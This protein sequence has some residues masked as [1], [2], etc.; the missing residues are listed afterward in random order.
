MRFT[1]A[2]PPALLSTL[3]LLSALA[4]L[5]SPALACG[6]DTDCTV[7]GDRTYR[8]YVP[9]TDGPVGAFFYAHGYRGSADGAMGNQALRAMADR[10]GMAFIAMNAD[11]DD[12]NLAHRPQAPDQTEAAEYDY[13]TAVIEDVASRIDLDQTR[14]FSTGFSAGGMMTW[15]LACAMGDRFAGF[16]P[17]S[18]TF[19]QSAPATCPTPAAD[20]V[21]IHGERDTVVPMEGRA[22]AGTRQGNVYDVMSMYAD[23]GQQGAAVLQEMPEGLTCFT[24]ENAA[25]TI[26]DLCM[27]DGGHS[28]SA[29]RVEWAIER[30]LSRL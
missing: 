23:F 2:T 20:L 29:A 21:H 5:A 12:W 17:Y 27:F 18:G 22:I 13:V 6:P 11:A 10:L 26:L 7:S 28:F 8:L 9:D 30:I 4:F 14:L 19:W 3:A 15:T 24:R 1:F 25:G 16:I